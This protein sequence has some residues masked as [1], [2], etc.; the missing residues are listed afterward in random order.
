MRTRFRGW[1]RYWGF[2]L[3][4]EHIL[5]SNYDYFVSKFKNNNKNYK[6]EIKK[7]FTKKKKELTAA[8]SGKLHTRC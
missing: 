6:K 7:A 8:I 4:V 5:S 3:T 2:P 1:C